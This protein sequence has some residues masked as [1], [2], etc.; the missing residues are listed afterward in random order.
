MSDHPA[1][2]ECITGRGRRI[3]RMGIS[4]A[5]STMGV[6]ARSS[7]GRN[8]HMGVTTILTFRGNGRRVIVPS[9]PERRTGHPEHGATTQ[10]RKTT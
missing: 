1:V 7:N 10:G 3:G 8:V 2:D 9:P 5:T 6:D 4:V